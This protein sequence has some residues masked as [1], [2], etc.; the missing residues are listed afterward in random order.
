ME[1]ITTRLQSL[2]SGKLMDVVKNYRQYGYDEATRDTAIAIL[3]ERG[4]DR[5]HLQRTGNLT[6]NAYD[7]AKAYLA[8]FNRSS[9]IAFVLYLLF[10]VTNILVP[11]VGKTSAFSGGIMWIVN[12]LL[13]SR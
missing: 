13:P 7:L 12:L 6:N 4:I 2:E 10:L 3:G 11:V 8:A 1:D 9:G 5:E